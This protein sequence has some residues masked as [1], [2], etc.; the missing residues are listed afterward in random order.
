MLETT[1]MSVNNSDT[2]K[3]YGYD[4]QSVLVGSVMHL[5]TLKRRRASTMMKI[6]GE[7]Q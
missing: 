4:E 2:K 5:L 1:I 7:G 3:Q 6:M